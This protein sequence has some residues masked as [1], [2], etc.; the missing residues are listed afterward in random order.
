[1][2]RTLWAALSAV[3]LIGA[4]PLALAQRNGNMPHAAPF[5][6][7]PNLTLEQALQKVAKL[8]KSLVPL[9]NAMNAAHARLK[10]SPK[11]PAA[12]KSYVEATYKYGHTVMMDRGKLPPKIQYRAALALYRRALNVD[13]HHQPSL[14]DKKTIEDIYRSMGMSIP[15]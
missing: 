2:K 5:A 12:K 14:D 3:V 6:G 7:G 13:P 1:M 15:K 8:D 10:K 11:D 9:E 4:A